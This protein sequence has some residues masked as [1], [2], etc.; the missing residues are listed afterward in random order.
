MRKP[1]AEIK[2]IHCRG[3]RRCRFSFLL[4]LRSH[5]ERDCRNPRWHSSNRCDLRIA[6]SIDIP[7]G[8]RFSRNYSGGLKIFVLRSTLLSIEDSL[9]PPHH[10]SLPRSEWA[11]QRSGS[12]MAMTIVAMTALSTDWRL[13]NL[14]RINWETKRDMI[15]PTRNSRSEKFPKDNRVETATRI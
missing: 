2:E 8:W 12:T 13:S 4:L 15:H 10:H 5:L 7:P 14:C 11:I 6:I 1:L 3:S 9:L